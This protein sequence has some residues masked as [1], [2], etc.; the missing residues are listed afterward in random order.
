[1][2]KNTTNEKIIFKEESFKIQGALY[3][4]YK[5]IGP[6]FLESVYQECLEMEL[7]KQNIPF[8]SQSEIN[9]Y[10]KE[11]LLN[12]YF[13]ADFI[14]YDSILLELKSVKKIEDIHRA[15]IMNYLKATGLK[16]GL[17]INFCAFPIIAIERFINNKNCDS[18]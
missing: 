11:T 13:K 17:L 1:M 18:A 3:E 10:Y 14:C 16:L 2:I 15:Q 12:L 6:G 7:K 8:K 4:V 5:E 9:I